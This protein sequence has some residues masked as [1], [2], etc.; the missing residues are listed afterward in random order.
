MRAAGHVFL[1][2]YK[3]LAGKKHLI[4][5]PGSTTQFNHIAAFK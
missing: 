3:L 2:S 1:P 5:S 4:R